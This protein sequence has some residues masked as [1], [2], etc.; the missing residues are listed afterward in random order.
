[1]AYISLKLHKITEIL[2]KV[3][4]IKKSFQK[5]SS[6]CKIDVTIS[7]KFVK[8]RCLVL[9]WFLKIRHRWKVQHY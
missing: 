9:F 2:T 8:N 3:E 6:F 1:M 4:K 7:A 5:S